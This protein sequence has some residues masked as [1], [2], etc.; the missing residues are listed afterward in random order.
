M[1]ITNGY[2]T[3]EQLKGWIISNRTANTPDWSEDDDTNMSRAIEAVSRVLDEKF[4]TNFYGASET[5]YYTAELSDLLFLPDDLI[6]I[7]TLKTDDDYD[8][9]YETTWATTDYWL[10]P[11]NARVKV[12]AKDMK[13]YRQIRINTNG[14]NA[15]PVDLHHAI[16][17]DGT[18]G[19]TTAT[20]LII[21]QATLMIAHRTWLRK[22]TIFGL[23]GVPDL[24]VE[25]LQ[26]RIQQD[27]DIQ[28]LLTG[29]DRRGFYA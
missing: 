20:P 14:D 10:E 15:F 29:I 4:D 16:E 17:I 12:N 22:D 23:A 28:N 19:Y 13:P 18:W 26:A 6:S 1:S 3:L 2:C 27:S 9:T 24:G 5:R 21:E 25:I 11:R 7:T 8:Q